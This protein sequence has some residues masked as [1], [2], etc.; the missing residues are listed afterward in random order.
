MKLISLTKGKFAK[1][2]D[3]DFDWLN[4]WKWQARKGGYTWY[5]QRK[6]GR[7][8]RRT[9]QMHSLILPDAKRVDH[10]DGDGLNN[11]RNNLRPASATQ[12]KA[13]EKVRVDNQS[14][15]RGVHEHYKGRW[16]AVLYM[17]GKRQY[18]G[19]FSTAEEAAHAY[20]AAAKKFFGEFAR[21]NFP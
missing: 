13:N 19:C 11:V 17:N 7:S 4:Q 20:D 15:Y 14:G 21:L 10:Q 5:A 8:S 2:D 18:S 6:A 16:R 12:N 9:V 3:A 1:V